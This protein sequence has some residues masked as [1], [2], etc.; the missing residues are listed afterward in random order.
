[1]MR[2]P[3]SG[4]TDWAL[5]REKLASGMP[6]IYNDSARSSFKEHALPAPPPRSHALAIWEAAV[7]AARPEDLLRQ[8]FANP[9]LPLHDAAHSARRILIVGGGKAGAAMS[10]GVEE[11]LAT[12][13]SRI[14]GVV[15]VPAEVVR[16]LERIRLYAARPAGTNHPT[17]EGVV[18][19]RAM[20]QLIRTA[21]PEDIA[22]CLLSGG[23]SAL[24]PSPVEGVSLEDKQTLT[25]LL[26]ACGATINE[27]NCVRK[28]LSQV[29]GGRLAQAFQGRCLY[30]LIISDAIGD[31]LDVIASGPTSPDPT[32]F[33]DALDVLTKY[34]LVA[35]TPPSILNHLNLGAAGGIPE[36]PKQLPANIHNVVIGNNARSLTAA[37]SM[38]NDLKYPVLN[39]GSFIAGETEQAALGLAGIIRS[40]LA[41]GRPM[42]SPVCVL[43][44]GETTVTLSANHGRGGRNQEFVLALMIALGE[45]CMR[46]LLVLSGG[47]DGEDGPT[48][49]AGAIADSSTW[50]RAHAK[51]VV[52]SEY[53]AGHDSYHFFEETG[54]LI[55][56]GLTQTNVMDVHVVL[57]C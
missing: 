55:K 31:P 57:V 44:G 19:T 37:E 56:T 6:P 33:A 17:A 7:S 40:I 39:L 46:R 1:M 49:A 48:D 53:L 5:T 8:T 16:T 51:S 25:L 50:T 23:G 9:A 20:M 3:P 21:N 35:Q 42:P 26:H 32:T 28:H 10:A 15:N 14:E 18:G 43:S 13:L 36:T 12:H 34:Q 4:A 38:A 22:L 30:S 41:D 2:I 24:M 54:G 52:P 45:E 11:A 29:K 27:M 47:T